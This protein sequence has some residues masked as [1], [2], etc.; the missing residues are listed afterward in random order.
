MPKKI[1][2][3]PGDMFQKWTVICEDL[4]TKLE[5]RKF[6]CKCECGREFSVQLANMVSGKSRSCIHCAGK[7]GVGRL[8]KRSHGYTTGVTDKDR[9]IPEYVAWTSIKARCCN[10]KNKSFP[11]Y[12]G[13]G[14]E[15]C[16]E[17]K[18][19]FAAFIEYVGPRTSPTHSIGRINNDKGYEPGNVRWETP[20]EQQR[21]SR[22][23]RLLTVNGV[24]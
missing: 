17:W 3:L 4:D 7:P 10:P 20:F 14:I 23:N 21:N 9:R 24:T 19:S 8:Y 5:K 6:W 1:V 18:Q 22:N 15:M 13:R 11:Y 16:D 2:V 12:G